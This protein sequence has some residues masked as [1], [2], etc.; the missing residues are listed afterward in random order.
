[1]TI[2]WT[3]K[4]DQNG[5]HEKREEGIKVQKFML[6]FHRTLHYLLRIIGV[7]INIFISPAYRLLY[8][9]QTKNGICASSSPFQDIYNPIKTAMQLFCEYSLCL[10]PHPISFTIS[11]CNTR[12]HKTPVY[13]RIYSTVCSYFLYRGKSFSST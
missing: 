5:I 9:N 11:A 3:N 6:N 2:G 12:R 7:Q 4:R 1:M 10:K 13:V 8:T